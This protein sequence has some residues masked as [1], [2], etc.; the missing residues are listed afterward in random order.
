MPAFGREAQL[1]MSFG[2]V[3]T[4]GLQLRRREFETRRGGSDALQTGLDGRQ[5]K[6]KLASVDDWHATV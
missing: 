5:I 6:K 2:F 4:D 1:H 3:H